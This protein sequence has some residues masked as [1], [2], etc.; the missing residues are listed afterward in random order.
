M[1]KASWLIWQLTWRSALQILLLG[2]LFGGIYGASFLVVVLFGE[3]GMRGDF[4]SLDSLTEL[5][6]IILL[7][8]FFGAFI[9]GLVGFVL[10][11]LIGL[12]ISV[13]RIGWF[14]PLHDAPRYLPLVRR[15]S[16]LLGGIGTL[17]G[18]PLS[19]RLVLDMTLNTEVG[20]LLAFSILPALLASLAIW[21]GSAQVAAWYMRTADAHAALALQV[22]E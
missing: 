5:L 6:G 22:G 7:A 20:F 12:L 10:G 1:M 18:T 13:I 16:V 21:R 19:T 4:F 9:G 3:G 14:R 2:A 11:C 17:I 15:L 8:V